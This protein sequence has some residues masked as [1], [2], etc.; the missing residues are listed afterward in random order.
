MGTHSAERFTARL[1]AALG[2]MLLT[3]CSTST[4]VSPVPPGHEPSQAMRV[5]SNLLTV[6]C[7]SEPS[8]LVAR[9]VSKD[10]LFGYQWYLKNVGQPVFADQL[11]CPAVAWT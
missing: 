2:F 6:T 11:P 3:A 4:E 9:P 8:S 1:S 10:P 5:N 7:A